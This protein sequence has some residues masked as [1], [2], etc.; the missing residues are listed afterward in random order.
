MGIWQ[1]ADFGIDL[2]RFPFPVNDAIVDTAAYRW[3]PG[4][5]CVKAVVEF[6]RH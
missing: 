1:T 3:V 6:E 2:A 5:L 4:T